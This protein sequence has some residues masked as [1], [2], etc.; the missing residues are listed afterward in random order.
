MPIG[1]PLVGSARKGPQVA[2]TLPAG[3]VE[4]EVP[5]DL[6]VS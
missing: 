6:G 4:W 3:R 5:F 2:M 1:F